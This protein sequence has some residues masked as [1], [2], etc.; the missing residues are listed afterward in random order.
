MRRCFYKVHY[1][2]FKEIEPFYGDRSLRLLFK[3]GG[4]KIV[5]IPPV[6]FQKY[7]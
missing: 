2:A 5:S 1:R 4:G 7:K 6:I 3:G